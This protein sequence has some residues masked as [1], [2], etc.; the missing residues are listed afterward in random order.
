M[1]LDLTLLPLHHQ[2]EITSR[3]IMCY[4]KLRVR[5]EDDIINMLREDDPTTLVTQALPPGAKL[6]SP[7]Y[8]P[9]KTSRKDPY[10]DELKYAFAK[11]FKKFKWP[12]EMDRRNKG[13]RAYLKALPPD[14]P[15]ILY[16]H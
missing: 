9:K 2:S 7:M 4:D 5:R 11:D 6:V 15:I 13:V 14:I 16:W 10:G 12:E 3:N 1:G 8:E